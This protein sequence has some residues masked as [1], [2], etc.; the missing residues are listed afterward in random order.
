MKKRLSRKAGVVNVKKQS[1]SKKES[2]VYVA[3]L[4][5][6]GLLATYSITSLAIDTGSLLAYSAS[7][8]GVCLSL[9][10]IKIAIKLAFTN[11]KNS[12]ARAAK[13]AR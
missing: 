4:A 10:Y 5:V 9:R 13:K 3:T 12:R 11:D 1:N 6:V 7:L 8:V 2:R